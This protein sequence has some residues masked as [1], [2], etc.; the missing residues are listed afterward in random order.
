MPLAIPAELKKI[1]PFIKRAEELDKDQTS[2]ESRL[3]AYYLRQYAVHLGIPLAGASPGAKMC[4]GHILGDLEAEKAAMDNFTRDEASFLCR[5][6]AEGVFNKADSE[7]R[8]GMAGKGTAKIFYAAA[9]FLQMLEQ[10]A[11]DSDPAE[12]AAEDKKRIVY[13]KW[14]AT[15][16]LKAIKEGREPTPGG[17]GED[18]METDEPS[19]EMSGHQDEGAH[20][21]PAVET[22]VEDDDDFGMPTAPRT[23]PPPMK[24]LPSPE[25]EDKDEED[26]EKAVEDEG[27]EVELG[28]PPAYPG[29]FDDKPSP[30]ASRLDRPTLSFDLPPVVDPVLPT[31]PKAKTSL[32]GFKKKSVKE[33]TKAQLADALELTRFALAAMEDRD[34][35]LGAERLQQALTALGR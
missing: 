20:E 19:T 13:G 7:D 8:A 32:F 11:Q 24:P 25:P 5:K 12:Q 16:I 17:Y 4:L 22:V 35:E 21:K 30:S 18:A 14:K 10:F 1:S 6:F 3:V 29:Q 28:P 15:E 34:A 26:E 23:L 9:S 31:P 27:T 2:P 33:A